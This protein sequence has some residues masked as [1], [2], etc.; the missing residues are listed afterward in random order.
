MKDDRE[1]DNCFMRRIISLGMNCEVSFQIERYQQPF[2]SSLFSWAYICNEHKF[3][4][5]LY[6]IDDV[7]SN[8]KHFHLPTSDM[9]MDEKYDIAFHGRTSKSEFLSE[10][11]KVINGEVYES[12]LRELENRLNHL[13]EKFFADLISDDE[14]IYIKKVPLSSVPIDL[15]V[16][17]VKQLKQYFTQHA[18]NW[19]LVIVLEEGEYPSELYEL[20]DGT[21]EIST[22]KYFSSIDNTKDGADDESWNGILAKYL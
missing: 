1:L 2:Y 18:R 14:K 9:F 17:Y 15:I 10:D 19:K 8:G 11:G 12:T 16:D 3:L 22:V 20:M 21:C 5:A 13:K 7:F 4:D 6:N